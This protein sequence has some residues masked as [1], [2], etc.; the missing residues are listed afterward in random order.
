MND[1]MLF[2][3]PDRGRQQAEVKK[4]Q[5]QLTAKF[6]EEPELI[7]Y[8]ADQ[9]SCDNILAALRN[10]SLFYA[11]LLV[12][13]YRCETFSAAEA[14]KI[15]QYWQKPNPAC[16]VIFLSEEYGDVKDRFKFV[17]KDDMQ[18]FW[19]VGEQEKPGWLRSY[20]QRKGGTI[21]KEA[22]ELLCELV[23]THT[24]TKSFYYYCSCAHV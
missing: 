3:G 2:I 6:K 5:Q 19:E 10:G 24:G 4:V 1:C 20:I 16:T 14:K 12:L 15:Q 23:N 18:V 17:A 9:E 7:S 13:I 22:L 21:D 8:Y 11:H